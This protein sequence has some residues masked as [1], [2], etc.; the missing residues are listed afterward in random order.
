MGVSSQ[1]RPHT[2]VVVLR[3]GSDVPQDKSG[4]I[5]AETSTSTTEAAPK[6]VLVSFARKSVET[7]NRSRPLTSRLEMEKVEAKLSWQV[8][9][10]SA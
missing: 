8:A 10:Q 6:A 1:S 3:D 5:F 9:R 2:G 7:G 4:N